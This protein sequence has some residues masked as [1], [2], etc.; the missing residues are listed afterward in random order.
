VF[1]CI[2]AYILMSNILLLSVLKIEADI[3]TSI[4]ASTVERAAILVI[5]YV[6]TFNSDVIV[7]LGHVIINIMI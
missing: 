1:L 2:F 4:V 6:E 5:M 7:F 3:I